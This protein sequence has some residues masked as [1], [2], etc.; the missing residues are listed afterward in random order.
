MQRSGSRH[1]CVFDKNNKNYMA[2]Q[3]TLKRYEIAHN[4]V[5]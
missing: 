5:A 1:D 2:L 4:T 3:K